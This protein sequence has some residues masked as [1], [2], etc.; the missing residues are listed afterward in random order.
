MVLLKKAISC[1]ILILLLIIIYFSKQYLPL[2]AEILN[3]VPKTYH[4]VLIGF[5][6]G[7]TIMAAFIVIELCFKS[8][9]REDEKL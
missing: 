3:K 7:I 1:L 6:T 8:I 9:H 4:N 2:F 5:T